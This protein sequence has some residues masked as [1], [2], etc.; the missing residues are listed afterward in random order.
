MVD[1]CHVSPDIYKTI[2]KMEDIV[3]KRDNILQNIEL[4]VQDKNVEVI[5]LLN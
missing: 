4:N 5:L 3:R 1:L 2:R